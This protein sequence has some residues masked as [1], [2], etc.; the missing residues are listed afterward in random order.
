MVTLIPVILHPKEEKLSWK[1]NTNSVDSPSNTLKIIIPTKSPNF[2]SLSLSLCL[3]PTLSPYR[4][5]THPYS[6][7]FQPHTLPGA[8]VLHAQSVRER[9]TPAFWSSWMNWGNHESNYIGVLVTAPNTESYRTGQQVLN[10]IWR[11]RHAHWIIRV[12]WLIIRK[13][14][15]LKNLCNTHSQVIYNIRPPNPGN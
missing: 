4:L 7:K 10:R 15:N 11:V 8:S 14:E 2:A 6:E 1:L 9:S 13:R 12:I 5:Q 3:I